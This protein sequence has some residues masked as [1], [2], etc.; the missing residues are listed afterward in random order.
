MAVDPWSYSTKTRPWSQRAQGLV[1]AIAQ[2]GDRGALE[3][4]LAAL[5]AAVEADRDFQEA[6]R[7]T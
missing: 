2:G 4:E 7:R 3:R 1:D 5:T 6:R